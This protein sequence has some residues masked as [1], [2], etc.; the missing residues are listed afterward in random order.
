[1]L[2]FY[3]LPYFDGEFLWEI[4]KWNGNLTKSKHP[5]KNNLVLPNKI[6]KAL[7]FINHPYEIKWES[8]P[9]SYIITTNCKNK[10]NDFD[11]LFFS[12]GN[13]RFFLSVLYS[14]FNSVKFKTT[15]ETFSYIASLPNYIY[16]SENCLQRCLLAAKIS[17]SF[18]K[19]GTLFI[20]AELSSLNMHAWIIE[21]DEQPDFEDRVWINYIPLLAITF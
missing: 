14:C 12:L 2:R 16:G 8:I 4:D 19:N 18:K 1:M 5:L 11:K 20:G 13:K 10:I 21:L 15:R 6:I 17:A 9:C 7:Y 3:S